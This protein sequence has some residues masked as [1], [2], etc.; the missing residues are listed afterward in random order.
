MRPRSALVRPARTLVGLIATL[1]TKETFG[2]V[3]RAA[4]LAEDETMRVAA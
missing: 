1:V 4:A 3:E 2:P